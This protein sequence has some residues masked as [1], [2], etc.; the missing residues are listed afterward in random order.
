[1]KDLMDIFIHKVK[2]PLNN[3]NLIIYSLK[4]EE[5]VDKEELELSEQMVHSMNYII[6]TYR[7]YLKAYGKR[8][9]ISEIGP[10]VDNISG[11][12]NIDGVL[13]PLAERL[14][15][16]FFGYSFF[17][18]EN[19]FVIETKESISLEDIWQDKELDVISVVIKDYLEGSI[20]FMEGKIIIEF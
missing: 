4:Q 8:V 5:D 12:T 20:Q 16:A 13:V 3:L 17:C 10:H 7:P 9:H 18:N 14:R 11:D 2:Q 19:S 6:E 15:E 1:M